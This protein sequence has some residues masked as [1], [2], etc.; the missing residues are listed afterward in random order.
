MIKMAQAKT[1]R[2]KPKGVRLSQPGETSPGEL[3]IKAELIAV[4]RTADC[5]YPGPLLLAPELPCPDS[6]F[7]L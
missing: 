2:F 6:S 5:G 3:S 7:S 4:A 1:G